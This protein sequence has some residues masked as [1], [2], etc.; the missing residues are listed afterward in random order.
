MENGKKSAKVGVIVPSWRR[1]QWQLTVSFL[2]RSG[3]QIEALLPESKVLALVGFCQVLISDWPSIYNWWGSLPSDSWN[4]CNSKHILCIQELGCEGDEK[5][6]YKIFPPPK[7]F[8]LA[9]PFGLSQVRDV[10]C[11]LV[12]SGRAR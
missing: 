12:K 11:G 6:F 2:R 3:F 1:E 9:Y 8:F 5:Q 10:M 7:N 4:S